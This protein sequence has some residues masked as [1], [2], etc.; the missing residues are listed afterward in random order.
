MDRRKKE[1]EK[2]MPALAPALPK[3]SIY[4][5]PGYENAIRGPLPGRKERQEYLK[6]A[7][8]TSSRIKRKR[9]DD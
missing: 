6:K 5:K 2:K 1:G 9:K 4:I 3:G 7:K 8:E